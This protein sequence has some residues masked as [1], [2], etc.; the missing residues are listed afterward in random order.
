MIWRLLVL[1]D[2]SAY[3]RFGLVYQNN[4]VC[5]KFTNQ[6]VIIKCISKFRMSTRFSQSEQS[7]ASHIG[8]A[9]NSQVTPLEE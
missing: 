6:T 3:G 4:M 5:V 1:K 2:E 8:Q 9:W 7:K